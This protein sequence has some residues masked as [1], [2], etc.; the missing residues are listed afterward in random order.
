MFKQILYGVF[1]TATAVGVGFASQSNSKMTVVKNEPAGNG[2]QMYMSYC[3]SCHGTDGR[4]KGAIAP[5]LK[6]PPADLTQLSKNNHG[7]YP[8]TYVISV[9]QSG[10]SVPGHGT[11][12]MPV[13][14]KIFAQL[15][16]GQGS[17]TRSLR[18]SNLN[19]YI[20]TLQAK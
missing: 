16:G 10:A 15:D 17:L 3:A 11:T 6:V 18:I 5:S 7:V 4:G 8:S 1:F 20:E 19:G 14:G 2:K 9:L 12:A 13:W